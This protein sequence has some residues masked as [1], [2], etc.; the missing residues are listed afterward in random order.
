VFPVTLEYEEYIGSAGRQVG[1][2]GDQIE[3]NNTKRE[4]N[5]RGKE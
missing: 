3:E 2:A 5:E 4:N 1:A